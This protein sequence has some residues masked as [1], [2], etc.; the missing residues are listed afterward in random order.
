MITLGVSPVRPTFPTHS[1]DSSAD[2]GYVQGQFSWAATPLLHQ[3]PLIGP[4]YHRI[5]MKTRSSWTSTG[6]LCTTLPVKAAQPPLQYDTK[7]INPIR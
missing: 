4:N 5:A 7:P 2:L 6:P 3:P 1:P